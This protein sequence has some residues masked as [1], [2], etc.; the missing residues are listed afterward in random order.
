M[1]DKMRPILIHDK[2]VTQAEV[3]AELSTGEGDAKRE[4]WRKDLLTGLNGEKSLDVIYLCGDPA[5]FLND[6]KTLDLI[7]DK[8]LQ[9]CGKFMFKCSSSNE[10]MC[11]KLAK[12][13]RFNG[14]VKVEVK[15]FQLIS[16]EKDKVEVS[17][18]VF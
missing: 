9:I 5:D 14:F 2:Y 10:E 1:K 12:H 13:M 18:F 16:A 3:D 11:P 8:V 17:T 6:D 15:S 7:V 4:V